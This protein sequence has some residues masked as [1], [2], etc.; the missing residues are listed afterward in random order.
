MDDGHFLPQVEICHCNGTS[1][2]GYQTVFGRHRAKR[3]RLS[4][5][6]CTGSFG[7]RIYL[8]VNFKV[9]FGFDQHFLG[10]FFTASILQQKLSKYQ[11]LASY[12]FVDDALG[13]FRGKLGVVALQLPK[14]DWVFL[15][16]EFLRL[17]AVQKAFA[18]GA[19]VL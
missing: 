7:G 12:R 18:R 3:W 13:M 17:L 11:C 15:G 5:R 10:R 4:W 14:A 2:G 19:G 6:C 8:A 16:A 9:L 1:F